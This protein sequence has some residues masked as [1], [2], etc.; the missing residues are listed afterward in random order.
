MMSMVYKDGWNGGAPVLGIMVLSA[1]NLCITVVI[2]V[3]LV[4]NFISFIKTCK[5][6]RDNKK[7]RKSR[8][9]FG[10]A[11]YIHNRPRKAKKLNEETKEGEI[12]SSIDK[13]NCQYVGY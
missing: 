10:K 3:E 9:N 6:K 7:Y 1:N 4:I 5:R 12:E 2:Y 13:L 8:F 11:V